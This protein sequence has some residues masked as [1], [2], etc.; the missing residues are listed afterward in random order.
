M[1]GSTTS[2]RKRADTR[3]RKVGG[4]G[5]VVKQAVGEVLVL[6]EVGARI[7]DLLEPG[8]EVATLLRALAAEYDIDPATLERDV[9]VYLQELLDAQVIEIATA[10]PPAGP[11]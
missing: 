2:F 6:S 4:E 8:T 3:Y 9:V 10:A 5:I 1:I 7:L 11:A